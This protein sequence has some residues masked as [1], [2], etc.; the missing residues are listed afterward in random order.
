[1]R[2]LRV[3]GVVAGA[4]SASTITARCDDKSASN[5]NSKN[6]PGSFFSFRS[7]FL[8]K[9]YKRQWNY[10][11]LFQPHILLELG[12]LGATPFIAFLAS[13][14]LWR[15]QRLQWRARYFT[16]VL[17]V[18]INEIIPEANGKTFFRWRTIIE[19]PAASII[20]DPHG[21]S[22]L[23]KAANRTTEDKPFIDDFL[24]KE[25]SWVCLNQVLNHVSMRYSSH[26][27]HRSISRDALF[28]SSYFVM[29][30]TCEKS[31]LRTYKIRAIMVAKDDLVHLGK[32][33]DYWE[34]SERRMPRLEYS[35]HK[36]RWELIKSMAK[37]YE[38][39]P[40]K[41][42]IQLELCF[43]KQEAILD[44]PKKRSANEK[45]IGHDWGRS[46]Y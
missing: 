8:Y 12:I 10:E 25:D 19:K 41:G 15:L 28:D 3:G 11:E 16:D 45:L 9:L 18:S 14:R 20:L 29:A 35:G 31:K 5:S 34:D 33:M 38:K 42:F 39:D 26:V 46:P 40:Q 37:K 4:L 30:L 2:V 17:N 22:E 36:V 27:L 13:V 7:M 24:S 6:A 1:M 23:H 44:L 21:M 32:T 43:P